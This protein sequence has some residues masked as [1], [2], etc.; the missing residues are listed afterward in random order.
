MSPFVHLAVDS[1]ECLSIGALRYTNGR[2]ARIHLFDDPIAVERLV[3]QECVK[4]QALDQWRDAHGVTAVARQKDEPHEVAE[5]VGKRQYLSRPAAFR[6]T[7]SLT[8][9]PPF[10]PCPARWTLTM[11]PSIIAIS[12]SGWSDKSLNM[13]SKT[14]DRAQSRNRQ[15]IVFQFPKPGG[16]S[17]QGDPVRATQKT[18]S[19]NRRVSLPVRPGCA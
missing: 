2:A 18:A 17:R 7:Y 11:V 14:P 1:Q 3:G 8:E 15:L 19:M 4:R 9:S 16:R 13:R 12:M 6:L 10:A 5:G